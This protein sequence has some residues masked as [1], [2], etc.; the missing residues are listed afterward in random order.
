MSL[1]KRL[2]EARLHAGHT[3]E[4]A[5]IKTGIN[6]VT[7]NKL[8][9]GKLPLSFIKGTHICQTLHLNPAWLASG[10]GRMFLPYPGT[11]STLRE[12]KAS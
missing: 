8:E 3:I 2:K 9:S 5:A 4:T 12:N 10:A 11:D 7:W 6:P 1:R